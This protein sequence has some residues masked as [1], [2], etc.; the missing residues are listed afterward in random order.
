MIVVTG[1]AGFIGAN[2]V[3]ALNGRGEH[4]VVAV[5]AGGPERTP[6]LASL[7]TSAYV[8]RDELAAWLGRNAGRVRAVL[9]MGACSDT[10]NPDRAFMMANNLEYTRTLWKF[11]AANGV[12]FVYASSAATYGDGSAGYDDRCDPKTL[13]PLNVYGESKQLFD[14]WA[15]EQ[16]ETPDG[17]A[18]LKFFNVYGPRES[19]KGRMASVAFHA[20][21]QI[22]AAGKAQLFASDR[23]GIP[24]GGQ[25]REFVYVKDVAA[26]VLWCMN[27][28]RERIGALFNVGTGRARSF[29]DLVRAVFA[30]LNLPAKIEFIPMPA[31]LKGKYQYFT[32]A[33]MQKLRAAGFA[34]AFCSLEDGVRDYV[35][36]LQRA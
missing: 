31:D 3:A 13:K 27:A 21:N 17:W 14:L 2:L 35:R 12:R 36:E 6:Y 9:H 24:D 32:E 19:H 30:A 25:Q 18:G 29:G 28:T 7:R 11:C 8:E 22:R 4:E 26:A 20:Y 1:A 33:R 16:R 23:M 10:T 5:D 34:H 15:L